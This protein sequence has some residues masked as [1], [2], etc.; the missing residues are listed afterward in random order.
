MP[1]RQ[2][3]QYHKSGASLQDVHLLVLEILPFL[4]FIRL[5][6]VDHVDSTSHFPGLL[7]SACFRQLPGMTCREDSVGDEFH[8]IAQKEPSQG[9]APDLQSPARTGSG[10]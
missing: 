2:A 6:E 5:G 9:L 10:S 1:P 4:S 3:H 8:T 7:T